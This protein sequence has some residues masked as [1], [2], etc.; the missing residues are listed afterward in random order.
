MA[1]SG[2]QLHDSQM[3]SALLDW[4]Q[5]PLVIVADN[6]YGSRRI[7]SQIADEGALAVIPSESNERHPIPHDASLYAWK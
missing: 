5:A 6:A 3:M 7:R 4:D 1:V 2:G